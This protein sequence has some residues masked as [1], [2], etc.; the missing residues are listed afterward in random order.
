[1]PEYTVHMIQT[2][3][4]AVTVEADDQ[5]AAAEAAWE[6]APSPTNSTNTGIDP[7]GDWTEVSISDENGVEIWSDYPQDEIDV[8]RKQLAEVR[9]LAADSTDG[10]VKAADVLATIDA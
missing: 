9:K 8:L 3:S 2:V 7:S 5:D 1:M 4:T 10:T 6:Q